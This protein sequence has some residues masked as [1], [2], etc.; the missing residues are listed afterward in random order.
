MML[1]ATK[2][3]T[4]RI[5]SIVTAVASLAALAIAAGADYVD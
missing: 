2:H 1:V 4:V 5:V 3:W